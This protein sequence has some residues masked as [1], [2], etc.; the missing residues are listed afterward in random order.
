MSA[1]EEVQHCYGFTFSKHT[2]EL[3]A[4]TRAEIAKKTV[5]E[6]RAIFGHLMVD[7]D[8]DALPLF[9]SD[10]SYVVV[11]PRAFN[12]DDNV[13][14]YIFPESKALFEID[15]SLIIS[16]TQ[17]EAINGTLIYK[18]D[19]GGGAAAPLYTTP[20]PAKGAATKAAGKDTTFYEIEFNRILNVWRWLGNALLQKG[21]RDDVQ[22]DVIDP[23]VAYDVEIND[24]SETKGL[25]FGWK[26][27]AIESGKEI[28]WSVIT[29]QALSTPPQTLLQL[30]QAATSIPTNFVEAA[31][32]DQRV[33][34]ALGNLTVPRVYEPLLPASECK[35]DLTPIMYADVSTLSD[36]CTGGALIALDYIDINLVRAIKQLQ[37]LGIIKGTQP[38]P[39]SAEEEPRL[40]HYLYKK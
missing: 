26:S 33:S 5:A 36:V 22:T 16:H 38:P 34:D 15:S 35:P 13:M 18:Q 32:T 40:S 30:M 20:A 23:L 37:L 19:G 27:N 29:G 3:E 6:K 1:D 31:L 8:A 28:Y 4:E 9:P 21:S 24:D 12:K 39:E 11:A 17:I 25:P 7:E 10:D 2:D 14:D